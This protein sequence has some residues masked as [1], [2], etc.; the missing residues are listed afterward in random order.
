MAK[1][2]SWQS[3]LLLFL[4][5][6]LPRDRRR[7][8]HG[9][10]TQGMTMAPRIFPV[11]DPDDR[12]EPAIETVSST[13]SSDDAHIPLARGRSFSLPWRPRPKSMFNSL[14]KHTM[15]QNFETPTLVNA[16]LHEHR[17]SGIRRIIR[18]A[19]TS[20]RGFVHKEQSIRRGSDE[21]AVDR[22]HH[23]RPHGFSPPSSRPNTSWQKIRQRTSFIHHSRDLHRTTTNL[24][25]TPSPSMPIPGSGSEPPIIPRHTG[26]AAKA[27]AAAAQGEYLSC[28]G[29][30][31]LPGIESE[32]P[33]DRESGIGISLA[34]SDFGTESDEETPDGIAKVD[35]IT[36][37]PVEISLEVLG[38]LD[39]LS[40]C[41]A[42]QVSR[43]WNFV[44]RNQHTWRE[45]FLRDKAATFATPMSVAPGTGRG[46]PVVRPNTNWKHIYQVR[47][48]LEKNWREGKLVPTHLLGHSDSIYCVQFDEY[49]SPNHRN[50][51]N[52][53][54]YE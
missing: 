7:I 10:P 4:H 53:D 31:R 29:G 8:A 44:C 13:S 54:S 26:A 45:S 24:D 22:L 51:T 40:L 15:T 49:V 5:V 1:L 39:G 46:I 47:S 21:A 9:Q 16:A 12:H 52:I 11:A 19:S 32:I 2:T 25:T 34:A 14:T 6:S 17:D 48:Q 41:G 37:L 3:P 20:L 30:L 42:S 36:R 23:T 28:S 33:G 18:R 35:F 50:I 27:A 38:L 43:M